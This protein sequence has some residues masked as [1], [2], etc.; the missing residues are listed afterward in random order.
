MTSKISYLGLFLKEERLGYNIYQNEQNQFF[1][2]LDPPIPLRCEVL[3]QNLILASFKIYFD[4][5]TL[6]VSR[7][8]SLVIQPKQF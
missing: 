3:S 7:M 1:E 4:P 6:L 2:R 8:V 5:S